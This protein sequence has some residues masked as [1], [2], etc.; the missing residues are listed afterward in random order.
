[1]ISVESPPL[2]E[3]TPT[4]P[5]SRA[6]TFLVWATAHLAAWRASG[7]TTLLAK[8]DDVETIRSLAKAAG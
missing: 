6:S 1:M 4:W 2:C 7:V 5:A 8:V 3:R